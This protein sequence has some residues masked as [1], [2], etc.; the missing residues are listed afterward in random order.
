MINRLLAFVHLRH[1]TTCFQSVKD[2]VEL[3]ASSKDQ[4]RVAADS[5]SMQKET[6]E[7]GQM[8][9]YRGLRLHDL[10]QDCVLLHDTIRQ[11]N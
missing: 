7:H 4:N 8:H 9:G 3:E 11:Q 1:L 2:C 10:H 5:A 6:A